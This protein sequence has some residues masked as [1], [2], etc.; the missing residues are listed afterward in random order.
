MS[1]AAFSGTKHCI[2]ISNGLDALR[3]ALSALHIGP[4]DEVIVPA[5]TYIA[6]VFAVMQVGARPVLADVD[7]ESYNVTAD[8]ISSAMSPNTKA[9]IPVHLYGQSCDMEAIVSLSERHAISIIEDNAQAQGAEYRG[10]K[11]G[12]FGVVNATSFYPSKNLG[13]LGDAGAITTDDDDVAHTCRLLGN[14]GSEKKYVHEIMGYNARM[15]SIQAA[16][17]TEKL[18]YLDQWNEERIA[19]AKR[20]FQ[21]LKSAKTLSLPGVQKDCKHVFHLFVVRSESRDRLQNYLKGHGIGTLIH[22][23]VPNH[24]QPALHGLGYAKGDFPVAEKISET[25]LSLPM[26]PGLKM[27]EVDYVCERILEFERII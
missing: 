3:L 16:F 4:G 25:C 17:L 23:P 13:A 24:L 8:T 7:S 19:I 21:N 10:R 20:Y 22:Y 1:Y 15:D 26:Y 12:S 6:T 18:R 5:H 9:V 2:G 27:D 11:T 14:V